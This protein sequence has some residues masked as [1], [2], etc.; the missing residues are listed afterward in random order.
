ML[1]HF[2]TPSSHPNMIPSHHCSIT[3]PLLFSLS[4]FTTSWRGNEPTPLIWGSEDM[5]QDVFNSVQVL[6]FF[7]LVS[8]LVPCYYDTLLNFHATNRNIFQTINHNN[9]FFNR[10][11][12]CTPLNLY[13][14]LALFWY[15]PISRFHTIFMGILCPTPSNAALLRSRDNLVL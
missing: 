7:G 13:S 4:L 10:V 8:F 9:C 11:V 12:V 2:L 14:G 1:K 15:S 3:Y 5:D 6:A